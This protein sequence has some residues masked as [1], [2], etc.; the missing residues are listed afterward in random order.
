[1][2]H[3]YAYSIYYDICADEGEKEQIREKVRLITDY[4]IENDYYLIDVDGEPTTWGKWNFLGL[5]RFRF[6][7]RGLNSLELLSHLKTAYHITED[8]KYQKVY[9]DL[10]ENHDYA[11]FTVR[12]KITIP[13]YVNH[14]DDELAF[15]SYYPLLKYEDDPRL[16]GIYRKSIIRSWE[17]EQPERCPLWNYIYAA[18]MPEGAWFDPEGAIFTLQRISLDLVEWDHKNTHRADLAFNSLEK[19]R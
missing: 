2:G 14:S 1:M 5:R 13:M 16:L 3:Y 15:L 19:C 7:D 6:W 8:D 11:R 4:I 17:I 10:V 18:T 9:L 12:Q